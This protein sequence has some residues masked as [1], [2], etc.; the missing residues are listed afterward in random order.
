MENPAP[1]ATIAQR[2]NE[3]THIPSA[4]RGTGGVYNMHG[5][6]NRPVNGSVL[7]EHN[8][9]GQSMNYVMYPESQDTRRCHSQ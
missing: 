4:R 1:T 6:V 8:H 7:P 5:N 2:G 3:P 9:T